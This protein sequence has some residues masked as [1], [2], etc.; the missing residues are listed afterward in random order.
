MDY[1]LPLLTVF[2]S[3]LFGLLVAIVT[4]TL[5]NRKDKSKFNQ[6]LLYRDYKD[7]ESFYVSILANLD[8]TIRFTE[9]RKDY[10]ELFDEMT[11]NSAKTNLYGTVS[12]NDKL[13]EVS[14]KLYEWSTEYKRGLPDKIGNTSLSMVSTEHG[15]HIEKAGQLYPELIALIQELTIEI[16]KELS[17]LKNDLIK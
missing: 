1:L 14:E 4:W 10:S 15:K 12:I 2:L 17:R 11:S 3:G 13:V 8:K 16:R 6:E 7:K 9:A 5:A